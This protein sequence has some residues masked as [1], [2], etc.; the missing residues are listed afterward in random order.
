M[1][2]RDK[3]QSDRD[4]I[5][6]V[7][8]RYA[9]GADR[10]DAAMFASV[11]TDELTV[12]IRGGSFG[13]GRKRTV[14]NHQFGQEMIKALS[15]FPV[16]QHFFSVYKIGIDGDTAQTLVYMQARHFI[17]ESE[18][19]HPPWDMGGNYEH[20]L[21]RTPS[22][23]KVRDYTLNITWEQHVAPRPSSRA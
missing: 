23:W 17:A 10:R 14:S 22:G 21:V 16:T 12:L 18:G 1:S 20:H 2:D 8:Y 3:V 7:V 15:R 19:V 6:E 4:A 11:F 9:I 5:S 13:E